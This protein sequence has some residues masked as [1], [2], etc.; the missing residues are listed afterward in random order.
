MYLDLNKYTYIHT[1]CNRAG[2]RCYVCETHDSG[3]TDNPPCGDK[4]HKERDENKPFLVTCNAT[5]I[6][7]R[8]S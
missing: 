7:C 6:F 4:F 2:L 5:D 1:Y 3:L 8:V